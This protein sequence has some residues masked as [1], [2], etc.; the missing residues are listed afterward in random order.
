MTGLRRV[1]CL[2]GS[3]ATLVLLASGC[4]PYTYFNV[5]VTMDPNTPDQTR[6]EIYR[7]TA[8]VLADGKQIE[9][10]QI[11]MQ[12]NGTEA[13]RTPYAGTDINNPQNI[14]Y[15]IGT[16]D[17]STARSSGTIK[18]VVDMIEVNS[19]NGITAQGSAQGNV[20]P[21]QVLTLNLMASPCQEICSQGTKSCP[22]D[23][24]DFK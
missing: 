2:L 13:C 3:T 23:T 17:Y 14:T 18:F 1:V 21:G 20:N 7:C 11:L 5:N 19:P 12:I 10:G 6:R 9:G 24:C 22:V 15:D 16:M 8:Y 4:D